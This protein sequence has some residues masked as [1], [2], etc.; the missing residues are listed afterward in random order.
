MDIESIEIAQIEN[1]K[2][3]A[4]NFKNNINILRENR[5]NSATS[6]RDII[7]D[8]E[9]ID[10]FEEQIQNLDSK[11]KIPPNLAPFNK[12]PLKYESFNSANLTQAVLI[13]DFLLAVIVGFLSFHDVLS[14]NSDASI[15][16]HLTSLHTILISIGFS[17]VG[18]LALKRKSSTWLS[19]YGF[20]SCINTLA[21]GGIALVL[22]VKL[23][24][25]GDLRITFVDIL[26]LSC[27]L[28]WSFYKVYV[29]YKH[30]RY[31]KALK[32]KEELE[33]IQILY[34]RSVKK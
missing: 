19:I 13:A 15:R 16:D 5:L 18:A 12:S 25:D 6:T 21:Y 20:Y 27:F 3:M 14:Y 34:E 17:L 24:K 32:K 1:F 26:F 11:T 7:V 29:L 8:E 2:I 22:Y 30:Y 9:E 33:T 23:R 28:G 4:K 31:L 10:L